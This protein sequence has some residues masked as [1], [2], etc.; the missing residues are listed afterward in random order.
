[1]SDITKNNGGGP[2]K[3]TSRYQGKHESFC[4]PTSGPEDVLFHPSTLAAEFKKY[5]DRLADY[6]GVLFKHFGPPMRKA[7]CKLAK[8]LFVLPEQPDS[9]SKSYADE[10]VVWTDAFTRIKDDSRRFTEANQ[11]VFNL[12]KQHITPAMMQKLRTHAEWDQVEYDMDGVGL[13]IL[14]RYYCHRKG[15]GEKQ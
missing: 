12:L 8:L 4:A 14:L 13:S 5:N 2:G 7:L 9:D 3:Q 1:M 15:A 10:V 11:K 6:V